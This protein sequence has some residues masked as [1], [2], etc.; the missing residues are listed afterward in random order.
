LKITIHVT[1]EDIASGAPGEPCL[2]P[3]A[4][5]IMRELPGFIPWVEED[6]IVES[7][8]GGIALAEDIPL[9]DAAVDFI[10]A[11]DRLALIAGVG[12][13]PFEFDIDVPDAL[14]EAVT[15]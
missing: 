8:R 15:R 5:A 13:G 1:A 11:Y 4:L 3:I 2:C 10:G 7:A 14:L 6:Q 9:P 12:F